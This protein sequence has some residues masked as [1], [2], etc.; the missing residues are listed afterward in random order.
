MSNYLESTH[1]RDWKE[2][3]Y[4][5]IAG[6]FSDEE[7]TALQAWVNDIEGRKPTHDKWMHHFEA[8]PDGTRDCPA[9]K[10]SC[11]TILAWKK[12]LT[13]GK[14]LAVVSEL[15]GEPA[16][17]YKEKI[18]YKYPGGGGYAPHQDAPAYEFVTFHITCLISVDPATPD[19]GCLS[20]SPGRYE[21]DFI[22]LDEKGCIAEEVAAE[23]EWVEV[24]TE[25]GDILLFGSYIPHKSGT[26]RSRQPRRIIYVTY[27]ALSEGDW[28]EQYYEDKRQAFSEYTKSSPTQVGQISKIGHFR[29]RTVLNHEQS[30]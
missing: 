20:F 6:F 13:D 24:P 3:N 23:M 1:H 14:V 4:L 28:R 17:L 25:P 30:D 11:R 2:N 15:M 26:N 7:V 12:L 27:N 21:R 19:S 22:A 16:V 18:N 29:G 9:Q 8:T 5:K 10:I